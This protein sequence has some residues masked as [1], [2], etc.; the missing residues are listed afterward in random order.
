MDKTSIL[1]LVVAIVAV[2]GVV[3]VASL[4][5]GAPI[6]VNTS[7][8]DQRNILTVS[9]TKDLEVAPDQAEILVQVI[10][11]A[12]TAKDA[13][14]QNKLLVSKVMAEIQS[15]GVA[16]SDIET[17]DVYL[18]KL[19]DWDYQA[20]KQI[21][22]GYQQVTTLKVTVKNLDNTGSVLDAAITGGANSIQD[23][24]FSLTPAAEAQYKKDALDAATQMAADKAKILAGA[25]GATLGKV[26]AINE[27][28]YVV[29]PWRYA[30]A[31]MDV[32]SSKAAGAAPTPINPQ[33][34]SLSV[35]VTV[36]YELS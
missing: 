3:V 17:Q 31:M 24:S 15:E 33:K 10:T 34:V 9:G 7:P 19:T 23:V 26:T 21:D 32:A 12:T 8:L 36:S 6:T 29:T 35:S 20:Q 2:I 27:N 28:S 25:A 4:K 1:A 14:N 13:S 11:N 5:T 30:G 16:K 22:R 18:N